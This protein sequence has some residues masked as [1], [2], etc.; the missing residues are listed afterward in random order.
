MRSDRSIL[1][2][3]LLAAAT[4]ALAAERY[5]PP[6][7]FPAKTYPAVDDHPQEKV[8]IAAD[9]YDMPD[10]AATTFHVPYADYGL[11]PVNIV[12]TNDS[13]LALDLK[14]MKLEL[15]TKRR[16]K[17]EADSEDDVFRRISHPHGT[18][19]SSPI[20]LPLP[21]KVKPAVSKEARQEVHDAILTTPTVPPHTTVQG[22]AFFDVEG[23]SNPLAGGTI[24]ITGI[25]DGKGQ[26]LMYFE[27]PLEK[28]LG[29]QPGV[30]K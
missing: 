6:K 9:P 12:I 8:S 15:V 26:E 29:Y 30:T 17:I 24:Y 7:L 18:P 2:V 23:L 16:D 21:R 5:T 27:I 20:P 19:G 28:Y 25:D 13:D 14:G 4:F 10:K 11:L 1:I 22:F 3:L